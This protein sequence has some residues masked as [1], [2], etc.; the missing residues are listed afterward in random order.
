MA[1]SRT[2]LLF[3][4]IQARFRETRRAFQEFLALPTLI[5]VLFITLAVGAYL[6]ERSAYKFTSPIY[7]FFEAR[8]FVDAEATSDLLGNIAG[9]I[10]TVT[11]ITITL[12]LLIVQQSA[13]NLT[14]Q[15]FDQF[16][17]RHSNQFFFGFFVGVAVFSLITLA[18][19]DEPF[20]PVFSASL[21]FLFTVIALFLLLVLFYITIHQMRPPVILGAIHDHTL[22]AR[23]HQRALIARTQRQSQSGAPYSYPVLS[24][25]HGFVTDINLDQ[26]E[27]VLKETPEVA[28]ILLFVSI[29]SFVAYR[30]CIA[31]VKTFQEGNFDDKIETFRDAV[32]LERSRDLASDPSYGVTQLEQ[33]A[34]SVLS[35]S[36][37]NL[38]PGLQAIYLLRDLL[39]RW[40][41]E[42]KQPLDREKLPIIYNDDVISN[43]LHTFTSLAVIASMSK[44][45][46]TMIAI[47]ETFLHVY[48]RLP[49]KW[50]PDADDAIA[51]L[52]QVLD[53]YI[54]TAPFKQA[55]LSF[56]DMQRRNHR[57]ETASKFAGYASTLHNDVGCQDGN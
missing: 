55:L 37:S 34:W 47:F 19:V 21:V 39:S 35:P 11:S 3:L 30:D 51:G 18:T 41:E 1:D 43:L 10:I 50:Q 38:A 25:H 56:A 42:E 45:H 13:S 29:G 15:V 48:D 57:A 16:L 46:Q 17:R 5:I 14:T 20:N 33:I 2:H 44:Q 27:R 7:S 12:L 8:V 28:E 52:L 36:K 9:S 32:K 24:D 31:E 23:A 49:D 54:V 40:V 26:L 6:F 22:A 4:T 53:S